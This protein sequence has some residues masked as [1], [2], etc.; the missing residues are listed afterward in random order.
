MII[1]IMVIILLPRKRMYYRSLPSY[2]EEQFRQFPSEQY[3]GRHETNQSKRSYCHRLRTNPGRW[4]HIFGSKVVNNL[5][6]FKNFLKL[7]LPTDIIRFLTMLRTKYIPVIFS[8]EINPNF[9]KRFVYNKGRSN[10]L[11]LLL[12]YYN[13]CSSRNIII[14]PFCI[15][16][17]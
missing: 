17:V 12:I 11:P 13:F 7:L 5:E 15:I 8:N 14:Y 2:D 16:N 1:T 4:N 3:S 10:D 6:Q 9:T